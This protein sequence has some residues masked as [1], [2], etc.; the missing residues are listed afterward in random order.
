MSN[1]NEDIYRQLQK[2]LDKLPIG[3]PATKSGIELKV[4]KHLFTPEDVKLALKLSGQPLPLNKVY[5]KVKKSGMSIEE[6]ESNLEDMYIKGLISRGKQGDEKYYALVPFVIG[7]FE[8]QLH[9]LTKEFVEDSKKYFEE[10]FWEK[11][12]NRTGIP[13][14]R[15][16]PIEQ[17]VSHEQTVSSFDDL[18]SLIEN[19]R[20]T[21][22]IQE[23]ICRQSA[24]VIGEPCEKTKLKHSCFAFRGA[25]DMYIE[26]GLGKAITKEEALEVLKQAEEDGKW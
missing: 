4:L 23:C 14:V 19:A 3:F 25:A 17:S 1:E 5:R 20:G 7:M 16:I 26:K 10:A 8:F 22:G 24:E 18:K 12:F 9:R 21:I 6:L 13:Q 11:E 2:Q 15:T